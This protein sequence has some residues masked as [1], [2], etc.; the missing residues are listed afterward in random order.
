MIPRTKV[1]YGLGHLIRALFITEKENRHRL[2]LISLLRDYFDEKHVLLTPSGRGALYYILKATDKTRVLIPAYT[3]NAVVEATLLAGKEIAYADIE[4]DGFNMDVS[5]LPSMVDE[6]TVIVAT[7]QFGIP[8][9]IERI[10]EIGRE[11]GALVIEDAAASLGSRVN[12]RLTGTFGDVSFFSFDSTKLINVPLKGGFIIAKDPLFLEKIED[13]RRRVTMRMPFPLKVKLLL[14]AAALIVISNHFLYRI[15]HW[16]AFAVRG[17]YTAECATLSR[18]LNQCY[19]YELANWQAFVASAQVEEIDRIISER[20]EKY[21]WYIEKLSA[22]AAFKLPPLDSRS[23]WSNIR[24]PIR[25]RGD[26][27]AYYRRAAQRGIDF[28]F[29]FT[30]IVCPEEFINARNLALRIL[31]V[32]FYS[33]LTAAERERVVSALMSLDSEVRRDNG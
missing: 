28:A 22:C 24:F 13:V 14:E 3:C 30:F 33:R 29:S 7:H 4:M 15:F 18:E 9:N 1:N 11:K 8:C 21:A 27:F 10:M 2:R 26:K 17:K 31:D 5:H 20:R 32:P 16:L 6:R 19:I 23:E 25:I 12:G